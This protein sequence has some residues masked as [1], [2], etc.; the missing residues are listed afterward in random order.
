MLY[1]CDKVFRGVTLQE[2][3]QDEDGKIVGCRW[4]NCNKGDADNPDVRCR[5]VAQ[6]VNNGTV[7]DDFYAATPPLEAKRLLFSQWATER[8]RGGQKLKLSFVDIRKAYFNGVPTRNLYVRLPP[9]LGLPRETL[10]KLVRCMYGTRDAGAIWETCYVDCLVQMG[11]VQ[12]VASPCCFHHPKWN[13]SVVVHGDDFTALGT[14][15]ALDEYEKGLQA[16]FEC[17]LRGRLGSEAK[18]LKEIRVLN[19]IVRI[20]QHGLRYE[21]DPRHAEILAKAMGLTECK[22]VAT[23]GVKPIYTEDS[24]DL[25][26]SDDHA[27]VS[28][29]KPTRRSKSRITFHKDVSVCLAQSH[30]TI[31]GQHP[32]TFVFGANGERIKI[33][34]NDGPFTGIAK[35]GI[36]SR[37]ASSKIDFDKRSAVFRS[38]LLNGLA[39]EMPTHELLNKM[40]PKKFKQKRIGAKAA[41]NAR[42]FESAGEVLNESE[43]TMFRALAARANYL[44][45]DR[46]ECAYAT[47]ELCRFLATPTHTGVQQLKR[48]VRYLAGAPRLV[49]KFDFQEDA[50]ELV[51]YVDTDFGGCHVT[52]RSTSGGAATRGDHLVK[53]WSTTQA[54]VAL[55]SAEAELTGIC[56][57]AS[58]GLGLQSLARDLGIDLQLKVM[59]DATAGIGIC[60]RRGLG[61]VRHLA[62]ADLWIQD[63][64]RRKG[65]QLEKVLGADS[66]ADML[67]KHVDRATLAK[68]MNKLGLYV[69][70]GRA[71][72]APAISE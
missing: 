67:T 47:K 17:K 29:L 1:F 72:S 21:A 39:W 51:T 45:L 23:L 10:G 38:A 54:T 15:R 4:V 71:E 56:K 9:E 3:K 33:K 60:R 13:V 26:M 59:T 19:R 25:P 27:L 49:W 35:G 30:S 34:A 50:G 12:G 64:L 48:L 44:A 6:E 62:T 65:F 53:H 2:A 8:T 40:S 16:T 24:H 43:A 41:K 32:S 68:H 46:P 55:S 28:S 69:E 70:E 18:D 66:P 52:R 57:G 36:A 11:F 42:R 22:P 61:E 31:Y 37:I 63:R 5:L 58:Q 7:N 14:D 20:T